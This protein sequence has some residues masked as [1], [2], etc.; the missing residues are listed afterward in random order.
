M[1]ILYNPNEKKEA[2]YKI[3]CD[4]CKAELEATI[5]DLKYGEF[6]C[7]Y[8]TCPCC[9]NNT[10]IDEADG[11]IL[12]KDNIEFPD[13]FFK[14]SKSSEI[15]SN[16]VKQWIKTGIENLRKIHS[17]F[18]YVA[19][20]SIVLIILRTDGDEAYNIILTDSY[21]ETT[22]PFKD[23]DYKDGNK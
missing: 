12:T 20:S 9:T 8:V 23:I 4:N 14:F 11:L 6:G 13:H 19:Q 18:Y 15:D 10:Y 3:S 21:Y 7:A 16:E 17:D 5:N 1:K 2:T 22:I